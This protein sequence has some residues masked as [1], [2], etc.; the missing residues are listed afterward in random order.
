MIAETALGAGAAAVGGS[1][2][3]SFAPFATAGANMLGSF[4]NSQTSSKNTKRMIRAQAEE[5]E[6]AYLRNVEMWEKQNQYNSPANQVKRLVE[7]GLN[8]NLAYGSLDG[9]SAN[10]APQAKPND[11]SGIAR[12]GNSVGAA[13]QSANIA[14]LEKTRA[15]TKL[16]ESQ[17]EKNQQDTE[18]SRLDNILK[19]IKN[20]RAVEVQDLTI[21]G[22]KL[23]NAND[24]KE[25]ERLDADIQQMQ[26]VTKRVIEETNLLKEQITENGIRN[27]MLRF[28]QMHQSEQYKKTI[29]LMCSEINRNNAGAKLSLQQAQDI[30]DSYTLRMADI[31]SSIA[32]KLT[33]I[34]FEEVQTSVAKNYGV[35]LEKQAESL[36]I[37]NAYE[38]STYHKIMKGANE[39]ANNAYIITQAVANIASIWRGGANAAVPTIGSLGSFGSFGSFGSSPI[40][41]GVPLN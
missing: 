6:K 15:E 7:A 41:S 32:S 31:S 38:G 40:S 9:N 10:A 27:E 11:M 33:H 19:A 17:A 39:F 1:S 26:E 16:F 5:N 21:E 8:P 23:Q 24:E 30:A 25:L 34:D 12:M 4:L 22:L 36:E 28:E 2:L 35:V 3:A 29:E 37:K 14:E 18:G 20:D 13:L